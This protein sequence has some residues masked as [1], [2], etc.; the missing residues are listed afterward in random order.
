MNEHTEQLIRELSE[1]LGTTV[2][3]LWE[4]LIRQA[5][6]SGIV[7]IV[8]ILFW[9][10]FCIWSFRFIQQKTTIHP[11]TE[12]DR[13]PSADW[14]EDGMVLAWILWAFITGLFLFIAGC[15]AES[16][17]GSLINPEYWALKQILN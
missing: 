5:G 11:K 13:Y 17:I 9:S 3:H 6:I 2:E 4:V 12:I 14:N 10:I 1:K 7:N 16:I 8:V 15:E